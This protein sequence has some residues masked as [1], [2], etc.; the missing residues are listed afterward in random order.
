VANEPVYEMMWD[1]PRC[2]TKHLL[3]VTH[4]YCPACGAPQDPT[5][6]YF[7]KDEDKVALVDHPYWGIDK[8]CA[9]CET[10]NSVAAHFCVSCSSPLDEARS[11]ALKDAEL[12]DGSKAPP[13]APAP[14]AAKKAAKKG[15]M[16]GILVGALVLFVG[17]VVCGGAGAMLFW[18]REAGLTVAGH[19]WTREVTIEQYATVKDDAWKADVPA[20]A[21]G[22]SCVEK[23]RSTTK[24]AD[25]EDCQTVKVDQGDGSFTEKQKCTTKY[26]EE[27][28]Y[29]DR[30]SYLVD[31]WTKGRSAR[32]AGGL[33]EGLA[34]APAWP[35]VTLT[36]AGSV[37]GC[38]READRS[39]TYTLSFTGDDGA[40]LSCDV[41]QAKWSTL[42]VGSKWKAP[43]GVLSGAVDCDALTPL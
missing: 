31:R 12:A 40:A 25:G 11:V 3:G 41:A 6:R 38:E 14:A 28:V 5:K 16:T 9:N 42:P 34:E 20:N 35:V 39:E 19:A 37:L 26:R 32:A 18:K 21:R 15:G 27:P 7:P 13:L 22:V 10:P 17:L 29:D 2:D 8:K 24:V 4:R 43:V 36:C 1:C 33:A 30:C 23:E